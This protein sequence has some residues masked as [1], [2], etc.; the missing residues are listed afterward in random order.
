MTKAECYNYDFLRDWLKRSIEPCLVPQAALSAKHIAVK[1]SR[2]HFTV[3]EN[4]V[5][6]AMRNL[7]FECKIRKGERCYNVTFT[8]KATKD[9]WKTFD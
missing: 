8:E 9:I 6:N 4:D 5:I 3:T 2:L 1:F 7:G